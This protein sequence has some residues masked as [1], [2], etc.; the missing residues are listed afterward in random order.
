MKWNG[1]YI[2]NATITSE[3]DSLITESLY[4]TDGFVA[5]PTRWKNLTIDLSL[6]TG[7]EQVTKYF[8][9]LVN[10]NLPPNNTMGLH[11]LENE[12][13]CPWC[14]SPNPINGRFCSQCG[15]PRGFIIGR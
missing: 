7:S 5:K 10:G 3:P 11:L 12:F 4:F 8:L 13:L 15:A 2:A 9:N 1:A 6:K 14:G